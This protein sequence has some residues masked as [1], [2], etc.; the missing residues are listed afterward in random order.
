MYVSRSTYSVLSS[1]CFGLGSVWAVAGAFKLLFGVRLS[2]VLLPPIGLERVSPELSLAVAA[3][4]FVLAAWLG[5]RSRND[6]AATDQS[7][8]AS[9]TPEL[10]SATAECAEKPLSHARA[11]AEFIRREP[12]EG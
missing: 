7:S 4:F 11:A 12:D 2:F 5:R 8:V 6:F 1:G 9:T 3:V 10:L